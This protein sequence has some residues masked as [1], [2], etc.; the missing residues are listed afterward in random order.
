V[1]AHVSNIKLSDLSSASYHYLADLTNALDKVP[2]ASNEAEAIAL[3]DAI[4]TSFLRHVDLQ[5]PWHGG[6]SGSPSG[7]VANA[8]EAWTRLW[9]VTKLNYD[10]SV[11]ARA[12]DLGAPANGLTSQRQLIT[13][14]GFAKG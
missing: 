5:G 10:F 9:G 3:V 6:E 2:R 1:N 13:I 14:G 7:C 4:A 12:A 11:A 8:G